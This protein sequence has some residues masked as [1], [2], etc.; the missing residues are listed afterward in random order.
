M[1]AFVVTAN[2][3]TARAQ[4]AKW[5]FIGTSTYEDFYFDEHI[6]TSRSP[7][8][9]TL[10]KMSYF[11]D[12]DGEA[13][14]SL[15]LE[16]FNCSANTSRIFS[17]AIYNEKDKLMASEY[18]TVSEHPFELVTPKTFNETLLKTVCKQGLKP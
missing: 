11:D 12:D 9:K 7:L 3:Q 4:Q 8:L 5:K 10:V 17:M 16:E 15:S 6:D 14:T 18:Y 1:M 13:M 2:A